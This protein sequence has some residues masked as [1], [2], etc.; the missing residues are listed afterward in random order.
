ML[1]AATRELATYEKISALLEAVISFSN[2]NT[3][4]YNTLARAKSKRR[5][6]SFTTNALTASSALL[7]FP[8]HMPSPPSLPR[9]EFPQEAVDASSR[10]PHLSRASH[11]DSHGQ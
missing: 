2:V 3:A 1:E 4:P 10:T 5:D 6:G 11:G 9:L 7:S 8:F